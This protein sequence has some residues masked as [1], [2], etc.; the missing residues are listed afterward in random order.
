MKSESISRSVLL[1][2]CDPT[3]SSLPVSSVHG[4]LQARIIGV[5]SY[6]LLQGI[7][8]TQGSDPGIKPSSPALQILYHLC[9]Q[10]SPISFSIRKIQINWHF[11]STTLAN[12]LNFLLEDNCFTILWWFL[13][14]INIYQPQV[15]ICPFL[16]EPP[17]HLPPNPTPLG[18]HRALNWTLSATQQIPIGYLFYIW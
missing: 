4:I 3:E 1:T 7:F 2:L 5:G 13:P 6:S 15:Y 10:G 14:Y 18:W 8:L 9:H 16:L 12:C 17:S 11:P